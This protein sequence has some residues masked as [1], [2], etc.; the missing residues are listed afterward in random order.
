MM[1]L[2]MIIRIIIIII[3]VMILLK[4]DL[5][6]IEEKLGRKILKAANRLRL[7]CIYLASQ[8]EV[9]LN[10]NGEEVELTTSRRFSILSAHERLFR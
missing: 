6:E 9:D 7:I 8:P 4:P 3:I 10:P 5:E 1:M 2:T